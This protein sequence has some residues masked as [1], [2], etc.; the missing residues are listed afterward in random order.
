MSI[1]SQSNISRE[2]HGL[3]SGNSYNCT[4]FYI[5][6]SEGMYLKTF[7]CHNL[8]C[9]VISRGICYFMSISSQSYIS[10]ETHRNSYDN[11]RYFIMG[12]K[13]VFLKTFNC[14]DLL[15]NAIGNGICYFLSI[16]P[17]YNISGEKHGLDY[18]IVT[19]IKGFTLWVLRACA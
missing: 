1:S 10:R 15:C 8:L 4:R 18:G 11:K 14:F 2:T 9:N 7:Y 6:G 17:K 16:T 12:S 13:G 3:A 19:T 5:T